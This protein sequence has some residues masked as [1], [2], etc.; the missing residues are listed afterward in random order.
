MICETC[1]AEGRTSRVCG[2]G[3]S[4]MTLLNC[5]PFY[6][7]QGRH[8]YHDSN[9]T[10]DNFECSNGHR[11][12]VKSTPSC[13]CGWPNKREPETASAMRERLGF[14]PNPDANNA[15]AD[16]IVNAGGGLT[17]VSPPSQVM[18]VV[19]D[20]LKALYALVG[21]DV[22]TMTLAEVVAKLKHAMANTDHEARE[23]KQAP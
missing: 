5:T 10:T 8:H 17:Y 21:A 4:Y 14:K 11:W 18:L 22:G 2:Q 9:T 12:T 3:G 13:W 20:D 19:S 1:K 6:D 23:A 16:G 15:L 7:E